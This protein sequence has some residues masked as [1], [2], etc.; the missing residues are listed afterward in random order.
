MSF[1][2][3]L[4][5]VVLGVDSFS[6][7]LGLGC[8]N[9]QRKTIW[10]FTLLVGLF[11]VLMPLVGFAL[12]RAAGEFL[13]ELALYAGAGVLIFWGIKIMLEAYR[14]KSPRDCQ[15]GGLA[16]LTLS[17]GVSVDALSVG[18]GLGTFG[19]NS[20]VAALLFGLVA[21][22]MTLLGFSLGSRVKER[23]GRLEYLAGIILIGLGIEAL[24]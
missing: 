1:E 13:G 11:H 14:G 22:V 21:A 15:P 2:V 4:V 24:I 17:L 8:H 23:L 3:M 10:I 18:F 6:L 16:L 19:I 5:A 20:L 12:G 9:P 7:S